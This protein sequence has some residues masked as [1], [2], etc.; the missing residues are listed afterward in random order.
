MIHQLNLTRV[1]QLQV[2]PMY[3]FA[4]LATDVER[5]LLPRPAQV[6]KRV[7]E[8]TCACSHKLLLTD[9]AAMQQIDHRIR[10]KGQ[11]MVCLLFELTISIT[12]RNQNG[13]PSVDYILLEEKSVWLVEV[14]YRERSSSTCVVKR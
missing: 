7:V 2:C 4:V 8:S 10:S 14:E 12:E 11:A 9:A 5:H 3:I 13:L 6:S 1:L